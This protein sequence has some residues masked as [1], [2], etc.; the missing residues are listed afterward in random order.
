MNIEV[1]YH[2][3]HFYIHNLGVDMQD[4]L[5]VTLG[6]HCAGQLSS[7][8]HQSMFLVYMHIW[9]TLSAFKFTK[10]EKN[11]I[12]SNDTFFF[13]FPVDFKTNKVLKMC[14]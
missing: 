10:N 9:H 13:S 7:P 5:G 11:K 14:I 1:N 8:W 3:V 2:H 12:S 6:I 4:Q